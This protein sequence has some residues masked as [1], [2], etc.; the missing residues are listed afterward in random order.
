MEAQFRSQIAVEPDWETGELVFEVLNEDKADELTYLVRASS[1]AVLRIT[2]PDGSIVDDEEVLAWISD[3]VMGFY[4]ETFAHDAKLIEEAGLPFAWVD[5]LFM[6]TTKLDEV[7]E[8][9]SKEYE[10]FPLPPIQQEKA[11][12]VYLLAFRNWLDRQ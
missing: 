6:F 7:M 5:L 9:W 11:R 8:E 12:K 3:G 1:Y 4:G 10:Y 2:T